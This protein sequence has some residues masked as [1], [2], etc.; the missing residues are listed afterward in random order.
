MVFSKRMML[1][2]IPLLA[3]AVVL[4]VSCDTGTDSTTTKAPGLYDNDPAEKETVVFTDT[5]AAATDYDSSNKS[6]LNVAYS[7]TNNAV[8]FDFSIGTVTVLS[9]DFFDLAIDASGTIIAN[10]GS[11]GTGVQVYKTEEMDI[12]GDFSALEAKVKEYTFKPTLDVKR[13]YGYQAVQNP[14]GSLGTTASPVC[15]IKVKYG[16]GEA[17]YFKVVFSMNMPGAGGYSGPPQYV[18]TVVPGLGAGEENKKTLA[19]AVTGIS[20]G[21]GW[22]YFKLV[23]EGAPKALNNGT[24]WT[25]GGTAVPKA[26]DWDILATR[27]DELQTEDGITLS[28]GMPLANRSSILLNVYKAVKAGVVA[29]KVIFEVPGSS[30]VPLR[31]AVDSIGYGWYSMAGMP[32]TFSVPAQTWIIKTAE[33]GF[34]KFQ[35]LDFA[36]GGANF[37]PN[38]YYYY[39]APSGE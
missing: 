28:A 31:A 34:A 19:T 9:H 7:T 23:G 4:W 38:F 16:S 12:A 3:L 15:L 25:G 11:Y 27:T 20:S 39:E 35:P 22:L 37:T 26:P 24:T 10:S 30:E 13:L 32:P 17:E 36:G 33:G 2:S 18:V 21:Y 8:F 29:D 14:L 6:N 1:L 5:F